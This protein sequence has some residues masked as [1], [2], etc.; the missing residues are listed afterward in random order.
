MKRPWIGP[1]A[2][3]VL[4]FLAFSLPPYLS[5]T[6]DNSRLP[7]DPRYPWHFPLL[8]GHILFGTVALIAC[9]MQ[10]WPWLRQKRPALHRWTGRV[11]V[12]GGVLPAGILGIFVGALAVTPGFSGKAGNV[13]LAI[14]WLFVTYRGFRAARAARYA[15]HRRWMIRSFALCTSIVVNRLWTVLLIVAL[16]P[17]LD[18]QFGGDQDALIK[19]AV[20]AG[21]WLSW[22]VN[23]LIAEWWIERART[24]KG[25]RP[26][27][28]QA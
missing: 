3:V 17:M 7:L 22:I 25:R 21:I 16:S 8:V 15:E 26:A 18:S 23:L 2:F 19:Q 5:F 27:L 9:S 6:P 12:L 20:E 24:P 28:A 14:V 4:V 13:T 11:Y 1:L 10:I